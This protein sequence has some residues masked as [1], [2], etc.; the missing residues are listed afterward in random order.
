MKILKVLLPLIFGRI[1]L[2]L[3]WRS[4]LANARKDSKFLFSLIFITIFFYPQ[5]KTLQKQDQTETTEGI[6]ILLTIVKA[7]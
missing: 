1:E 7:Y 4:G 5:K 2:P 3:T 6:P